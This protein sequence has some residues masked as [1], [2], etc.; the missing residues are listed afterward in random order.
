MAVRVLV[1]ACLLGF[2]CAYDGRDRKNESLL[3]KLRSGGYQVFA[4]CPEYRIFGVPRSPMEISGGD[5]FD[6]LQGK[7]FLLTADGRKY[8][9]RSLKRELESIARWLAHIKPEA[10]YL[11][12]GSPFCGAGVIYDGSFSGRLVKG[13]GILVAIASKHG[14]KVEGVR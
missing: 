2:R 9:R 3:L 10:A 5:G 4:I 13:R 12:E 1:S 11:R 6:F 8:D 14:V 7:A